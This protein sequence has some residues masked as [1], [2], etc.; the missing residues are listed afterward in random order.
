MRMT[1][2]DGTVEECYMYW[3][4]EYWEWVCITYKYIGE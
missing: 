1:Y 2:T 4:G 3:N